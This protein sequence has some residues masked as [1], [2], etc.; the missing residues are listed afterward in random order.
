MKLVTFQHG[1][2][3]H[4][5]AVKAN[6][7]VDLSTRLGRSFP[8]IISFIAQGG[9]PIAASLLQTEM[10]DYA[11]DDL[12]LLPVVPNP[13]KILCIGLNYADHVAEASKKLGGREI[14]TKPMVF[15]RWPESLTAHRDI[16]RRPRVSDNL[17]WEAELLVVIGQRV[18]RYTPVEKAL[19]YVF[20]YSAMNEACLRDYQFHS[21]QLTPG[22][23]FESTGAIGP[24]LVTA[25]EVGDPQNLDIEMRLNGE[26]MQTANTKDMV[27]SVAQLISYISEWLPLNPGD[28]IASGTMAG[29]GFARQPPIFMKPGDKAEVSISKIGTLVNTVEDEQ[30]AV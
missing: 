30:L 29:V 16:I 20:G 22:K 8:D 12:E 5:G 11:F 15:A 18:P 9:M 19:D 21:R 28:L 3:V 25:D 23:N 26:I 10:G 7:V 13:G 17:D 1:N 6:R 27:F 24:W 14:P 4:Y 2:A